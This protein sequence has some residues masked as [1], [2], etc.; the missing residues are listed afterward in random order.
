MKNI[1]IITLTF[2]SFNV[3]SQNKDSYF[4]FRITDAI[5]EYFD[6]LNIQRMNE[7]DSCDC[8]FY[9]ESKF[10]IFTKSIDAY[11]SLLLNELS[12]EYLIEQLISQYK[13]AI[14]KLGKLTFPEA[15]I[16]TEIFQI[17]NYFT[18]L[19]MKRKI[20]YKVLL[21]IYYKPINVE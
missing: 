10:V 9:Y 11:D 16:E 6:S 4:S 18:P 8:H 20:K 1:L 7:P 17:R 13:Q 3:F 5:T 12:D 14:Q 21:N 2:L 15:F 19:R